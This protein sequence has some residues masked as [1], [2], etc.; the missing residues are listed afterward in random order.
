MMNVF[1]VSD[2]HFAHSNML[3]FTNYEGEKVR[4]E[5]SSV[6][7]MNEVMIENWNKT[8]K[9]SS[10]VYHLGDICFNLTEFHKIMP[11][12]NGKKRLILGNHDKFSMSEYMKYFEKIQES[13]Q[14]VRDVVFTH[15]PIHLGDHHE[16]V[17]YNFHGHIHR[18]ENISPRHLNLC[19][20]MTDYSPIHW[21]E[22]CKIAG[23]KI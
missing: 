11:R 14:P 5:F 10:K 9:P 1:F 21:E 18:H 19:V 6:E 12:L 8:I 20:E 4:P 16:K 3:N 17:K 2:T 13:W 22:A 15:R 23:R 7:E